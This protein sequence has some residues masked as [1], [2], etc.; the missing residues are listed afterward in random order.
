M[1]K[2]GADVINQ[3][4]GGFVGLALGDAISQKKYEGVTKLDE[5]SHVTKM[6]LCV[7]KGLLAVP[8]SPID[9][10][11][12]EIFRYFDEYN[13][14]DETTTGY[15][16][17]SYKAMRNWEEA[18]NSAHVILG[19]NADGSSLSRTLPIALSYHNIEV[20]DYLSQKQSK[21]T[22]FEELPG[23]VASLYNQVVL[24]LLNGEYLSD[25]VFRV[26]QNTER[27]YILYGEPDSAPN[28]LCTNEF[29]WAIYT[30]LK[31]SSFKEV[32]ENS[33]KFNNGS[34]A[35]ASLALG[36]A[37]VY[38]GYD[39]IQKVCGDLLKGQDEIN[40]TINGLYELKLKNQV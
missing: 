6:A 14:K 12:R 11:G 28:M 30:V 27:E 4:K 34:S 9:A 33:S 17:T 23:C 39:E 13:P 2:R 21:L 22:H 24:R 20:V 10:I 19:G 25:A 8:S 38:Y 32:L 35:I 1:K 7:A 26:I 37:G 40:E 5:K 15:A 29:D 3:I 36:L 16:V 31:S 18:S